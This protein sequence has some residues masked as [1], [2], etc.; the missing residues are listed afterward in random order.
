M[1]RLARLKIVV[2]ICLILFL[3]SGSQ[4]L[5]EDNLFKKVIKVLKGVA[6]STISLGIEEVGSRLCGANLWCVLKSI[7]RSVFKEFISKNEKQP[8]EVV[9]RVINKL[10][11][12]PYVR[13][14][15]KERIEALPRKTRA[16]LIDQISKIEDRLIRIERLAIDT[17]FRVRELERLILSVLN[18]PSIDTIRGI[19]LPND[20][21]RFD[22][23]NSL[24]TIIYPRNLEP[25]RKIEEQWIV[26]A[27][28]EEGMLRGMLDLGLFSSGQPFM[29]T[30]VIS[31]L[32]NYDADKLKN[33]AY[34]NVEWAMTQIECDEE[35][36]KFLFCQM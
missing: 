19:D 26:G 34:N 36:Q 15:I 20:M 25:P 9:I 14:E 27:R 24:L 1:K 17:N 16:S 11:S 33:F 28:V 5:A 3:L 2:L 7:G 21:R 6:F 8:R 12:D 29:V 4:S 35:D 10:D 18:T 13:Q 31:A 30:S 22:A 23:K 32:Y